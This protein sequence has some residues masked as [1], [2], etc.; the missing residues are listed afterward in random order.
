MRASDRD[1]CKSGISSVCVALILLS[2]LIFS[3][4]AL[5][6]EYTVFDNAT[7]YHAAVEIQDAESYAFVKPGMLGEKVPDK[8]T[9]VSLYY[10]NGTNASFEDKGRSISF[11]KGNYTV[12]FD[13]GLEGKNFQALYDSFY[14]VTLSLPAGYDV[15]NP[16]LGMVSN[17]GEADETDGN[18]TVS[19]TRK[20][21]VEARFYDDFQVELLI[22]F[23]TFWIAL[24]VVF[25]VPYLLSRRK[26]EP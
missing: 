5:S 14:N 20:S 6:A 1:R 24:V 25:L 11:E 21:Y 23:G 19:W 13:S 17:G 12:Y 7:G 18:V 16:L 8:V 2:A 9:N 10:V 26:N 3:A 22:I 15:R 4:S